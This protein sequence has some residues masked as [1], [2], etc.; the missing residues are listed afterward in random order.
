MYIILIKCHG[1]FELSVRSWVAWRSRTSPNLISDPST[2]IPKY[3]P[4]PLFEAG[5]ASSEKVK[6]K[7]L[8]PLRVARKGTVSNRSQFLLFIP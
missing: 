4:R 1:L 3:S 2:F 5:L 7:N 8:V 6:G